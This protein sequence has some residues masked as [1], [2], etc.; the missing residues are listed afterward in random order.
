MYHFVG[1]VFVIRSQWAKYVIFYLPLLLFYS[2]LALF[3]F[4]LV[5]P[6]IH[7]RLYID[8]RIGQ[9]EIVVDSLPG[10]PDNV[11]RHPSGGYLVGLSAGR[12]LTTDLG[13]HQL[14]LRRF[15]AKVSYMH[16]TSTSERWYFLQ[17]F[18]CLFSSCVISSERWYFLQTFLCLFS[19]CVIS[20]E[21]WYFLQTFLCLFSSCVISSERW[22]FLQTFLCL[23]SS[24]VISSERWYFLQTFLCLF[25]SCVISSL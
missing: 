16:C 19:S 12:T 14:W 2:P 17:T 21:R 22:Y 20:S 4:P 9:S 10:F 7:S 3:I 11:R 18:L 25:S 6:L 15:L 23:F 1:A 8:E 5:L 24:C 13:N